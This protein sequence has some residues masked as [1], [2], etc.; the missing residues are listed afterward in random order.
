MAFSA[1]NPSPSAARSITRAKAAAGLRTHRDLTA[2]ARLVGLELFARAD[3]R[4]GMAAAVSIASLAEAVG[5]CE[6]HVRRCIAQLAQHGFLIIIKRGGHLPDDYHLLVG[7]LAALGEA[8]A[9]Q[10]QAVCTVAARAAA[11]ARAHVKAKT[12]NMLAAAREARRAAYAAAREA[13]DRLKATSPAPVLKPSENGPRTIPDR[14]F[15]PRI[16]SMNIDVHNRGKGLLN[17]ASK[18]GFWPAPRT[19]QGQ[20]LTDQQLDS[21]AQAR[22]YDALKVLGTAALSQFMAYPDAAQLEAEA[23]KAERYS[24]DNGRTGLAIIA[25]RL[26][27]VSA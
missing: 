21:K 4:T 18:S 7:K 20:V 27:G 24:P 9:T 16:P 1:A 12:G 15:C 11:A 17:L 25:A 3:K 22:V 13:R 26:N 10:V 14:T 8:V 19:P 23:I 6:R 5:A 2:T